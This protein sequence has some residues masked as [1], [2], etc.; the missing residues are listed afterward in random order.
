MVFKA[1]ISIKNRYTKSGKYKKWTYITIQ[2]YKRIENQY[3]KVRAKYANASRTNYQ[4][5]NPHYIGLS[6][7]TIFT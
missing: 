7:E 3:S 4:V 6:T 2:N 1:Y 5:N